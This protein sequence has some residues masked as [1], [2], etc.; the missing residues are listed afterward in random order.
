ML[1]A[2]SVGNTS[3]P[4]DYPVCVLEN[5]K[6][7]YIPDVFYSAILCVSYSEVSYILCSGVYSLFIGLHP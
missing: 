1:S 4:S 6:K 5:Q 7:I 3:V 2:L